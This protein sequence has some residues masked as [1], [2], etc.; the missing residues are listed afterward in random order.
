MRFLYILGIWCWP[1]PK[2]RMLRGRRQTDSYMASIGVWA[3]LYSSLLPRCWKIHK[4]VNHWISKQYKGRFLGLFYAKLDSDCIPIMSLCR[5]QTPSVG[6]C[7]VAARLA[8]I[9]HLYMHG[10]YSKTIPIT[11][12]PYDTW[13]I[14]HLWFQYDRNFKALC[15]YTT[16]VIY[17]VAGHWYV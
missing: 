15:H 3:N 6:V 12:P 8:L 11:W 14:S 7:V 10:P 17:H 2:T 13:H 5:M 4:L 16:A 9:L 1:S